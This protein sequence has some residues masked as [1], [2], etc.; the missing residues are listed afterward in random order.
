MMV[1]HLHS[2]FSRVTLDLLPKCSVMEGL[3]GCGVKVVAAK[4]LGFVLG[5]FFLL[6]LSLFLLLA[7]PS[8]LSSSQSYVIGNSFG[9][10]LPSGVHTAQ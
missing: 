9:H 4:N 10:V 6:S 8:S 2:S 5:F 3:G 7:W 1:S